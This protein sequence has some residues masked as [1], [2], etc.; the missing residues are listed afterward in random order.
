MPMDA[1]TRG[2]RVVL[3]VV[4]GAA[5]M[6]VGGL[7]ATALVTSPAQLAAD[8]GPPA[9]DALLATVE[10]R[11]LAETVVMRGTVVA[12]QSVAIAPQPAG[13]GAGGAAVVTRLPLRPGDPVRAGRVLAEVSG[14]PVIAL[15]GALPVYRD[16]R[17]GAEGA[18]V[19]QLQRALRQLGHGVGDDRPGVF[20]PG[21]KAALAALYRALGYPVAPAVADGGEAV[22]AAREAVRSAQWA[23]EDALDAARPQPPENP[24]PPPPNRSAS[25]MP[26][27][28]PASPA[29]L[30]ARSASPAFEAPTSASPMPGALSASPADLAAR[31]ASPASKGG[32]CRRARRG[33]RRPPPRS[34]RPGPRGRGGA[35]GG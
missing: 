28:L 10:R 22:R 2:R 7:L 20:G 15:H 30:A 27:A 1:L 8:A 25:P 11:V 35:A 19:G 23:L 34:G 4:A 16:L 5:L 21:T 31:S 9:Q 29:D 33:R 3:G 17:P 26:G 24:P 13:P 6:T 12:D 32:R 14:R 18:D